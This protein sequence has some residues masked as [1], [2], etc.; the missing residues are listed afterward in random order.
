[1]TARFVVIRSLNTSFHHK[2]FRK[3]LKFLE[4]LSLYP[5]DLIRDWLDPGSVVKCWVLFIVKKVV[6]FRKMNT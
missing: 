1:M 2:D 5:W 6:F 3:L 4:T